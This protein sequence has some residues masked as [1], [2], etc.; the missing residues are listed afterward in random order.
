MISVNALKPAAAQKY[1]AGKVP[2]TD[3][4]FAQLTGQAKAQAFSVSG[5]S[6]LDQV[7]AVQNALAKIIDEGGTL[8]DFKKEIPEIIKAQGW[9]G[10]AAHRVDNLLRTNLQIAY[11]AGR[12]DQMSKATK[13]RPYWQY[14]AVGDKRTRPS[15]TAL[16]GKVYPADHQFWDTYL[17]PNG[18]RCRCTVISLSKRQLKKSGL[19]VETDMPGTT[20]VTLPDGSEINV[21]PMPDKG[22]ARNVGKDFY[23][24]DLS[25]Y[26]ADSKQQYLEN[27]ID[28][29]C[30]HDFAQSGESTCLARLKKHLSQEDLEDM[31][32]LIRSRMQ[33]GVEGF[34]EWTEAVLKRN[35]R[36]R[37]DL[38]PVGNL[39]AKVTAHLH[40][41][42]KSPRLALVTVDDG[43]IMHLSR[44]AKKKRGQALTPL[45]IAEMSERFAESDWYEDTEK[46]GLLMSWVR[47]GDELVKVVINLDGKVSKHGVA[48]RIV[49]AG[50]IDKK[51]V[52]TGKRYKKI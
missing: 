10:K 3:K 5:L 19:Q 37:G 2:V 13:L 6:K 40:K 14:V 21:N 50:V 24:P 51:N 38:Y 41:Q 9:T 31:Q 49:T 39:P 15:H 43:Q 4:E 36:Q 48:N 33:G 8:A 45:E 20:M 23:Q 52:E 29:L 30:P 12:H 17:P 35:Y 25:K 1:W 7:I 18:F 26:P 34:E 44:T 47:L 27:M 28:G 22:W 16:N 11:M 42:G 46:E 32:T